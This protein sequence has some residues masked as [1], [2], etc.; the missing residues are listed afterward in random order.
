MELFEEEQDLQDSKPSQTFCHRIKELIRAMN[1]RT[2]NGAMKPGSE[3]W[4][5]SW[6]FL[7]IWYIHN[8]IQLH[9]IL[10][11]I[12]IYI[13]QIVEEFLPYLDTWQQEAKTKGLHF[14]S[15]STCYGLK[16]SLTATLEICKYLIDECG[17][18]YLMT[19]RLNQDA[20]EVL[21]LHTYC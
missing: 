4:K 10:F 1:C 20:L 6:L 15:D 5:V 21:S 12:Y 2:P 8:I 14:M 13:L 16:V 9:Y 3:S 19:A 17:F 18:K 11:M 7:R